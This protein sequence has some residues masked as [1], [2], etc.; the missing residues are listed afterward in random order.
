M[1][2]IP[3]HN[4]TAGE[5]IRPSVFN[6]LSHDWIKR[7]YGRSART[8][9]PSNPT[10]F[11]LLGGIPAHE[12]SRLDWGIRGRLTAKARHE[13]L[14]GAII[15]QF[16]C[17]LTDIE[18]LE[19]ILASAISP[20]DAKTGASALIRRFRTF[21]HVLSA[22]VAELIAVAKVGVA[23]AGALKLAELAVA[24][25]TRDAVAT[26]PEYSSYSTLIPYL[27][28][29]MAHKRFEEVRVMFL[30]VACGLIADEVLAEGTIS[31]VFIHPRR[32]ATRCLE[33]DAAGII[34]VHNHPVGS[35]MPTVADNWFTSDLE[36]ALSTLGIAV[37]DHIIVSPS[38][39]FSYRGNK[40]MTDQNIAEAMSEPAEEESAQR[41]SQPSRL[42]A[43]I[44]AETGPS[45][46]SATVRRARR[47][48]RKG[49]RIQVCD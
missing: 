20:R 41:E 16:H 2:R 32:I 28:A 5:A 46:A 45:A 8:A 7:T 26:E 24:R 43:A 27:K 12:K 18:V 6:D 23:G 48:K 31:Q 10:H 33:L 36:G 40:L 44:L 21:G 39:C 37:H 47:A 30:D 14:R 25:M 11:A 22:D 29:R 34:I 17:L 42:P 13:K 1:V 3:R 38:G 19:L 15:G 4:G 9:K 35:W 49:R